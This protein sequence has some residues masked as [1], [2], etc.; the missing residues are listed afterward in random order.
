MT[1]IELMLVVAIIG[2]MAAIA[3][4]SFLNYQLTSKRA[5]GFTNLAALATTHKTYYAEAGDFVD[6]LAEP[7]GGGAGFGPDALKHEPDRVIQAFRAVGWSPEGDVFFSYDTTTPE[8]PLSNCGGCTKGCFTAAAYGDLDGN[9]LD[10]VILYA[11]PDVEGR[12]CEAV[13]TNTTPPVHSQVV[14]SL[15]DD[16]Y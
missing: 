10:S 5:E 11:H 13:L 14:R 16:T 3:I 12:V 15:M 8:T 7:M 6:V 4:P 1:L 2:I 9:S